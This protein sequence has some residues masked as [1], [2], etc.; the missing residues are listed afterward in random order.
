MR[1]FWLVIVVTIGILLAAPSPQRWGDGAAA[2][3]LATLPPVAERN[4]RFGIVFVNGAGYNASEQRYQ[5]AVASGV[6]WT[7]WPMYW[8]EIETSPGYLGDAAYSLQDEV[9]AG[10]VAHGLETNAILLGTPLWSATAGSLAV[11]VPRLEN[12]ASLFPSLS[13]PSGQPIPQSS[14]AASSP[15][16]LYLPVFLGDGTINPDN[17]WARF[18]YTTVSRYKGRVKVWEMWNEPDLKDSNGQPVFWS[19][20]YADYYQ[21]LKVGYQAA[22]AADPSATVLFAGLAYWTDTTFLPRLLD[23]MVADAT[24]PSHNYYFD[25]LPWHLYVSPYHL[26]NVPLWARSEMAGRGI[27]K[28]IWV[29]ETNIPVCSDTQV[30]PYLGCPTQWRGSLEEQAS[31][32]IQA[33]AMAAAAGVDKTFVFQLYDDDLGTYDW[34]GL[35]R[36]SASER[37]A[38]TSYQVAATYFAYPTRVVYQTIGSAIGVTFY[39]TSKGKVTALWNS[40]AVSTVAGI[41]AS[42]SPALLV[43]KYGNKTTIT[44][45]SGIYNISLPGTSYANGDVGGEPYLLVEPVRPAA[46]AVMEALPTYAS[47]K[48][49][50][51]R[52]SSGST[53]VRYDV[54]YWAEDRWVTWLE[55]TSATSAV[56]GPTSP[57]PVAE[58]T[59][60][61]FRVRARDAEGNADPYTPFPGDAQTT[62]PF[63]VTGGVTDYR[64]QPLSGASVLAVGSS[65]STT[66]SAAGTYRLGTYPQGTYLFAASRADFGQWPPKAI[67]MAGTIPYDFYLP[68]GDNLIANG[69]FEEGVTGWT[70]SG[71]VLAKTFRHSGDYGAYLSGTASLSQRVY[72]PRS[73][74]TLSLVYRTPATASPGQLTVRAIGVGGEKRLSQ[75]LNAEDAWRHAWIDLEALQGDVEVR[76]ELTGEGAV[77][78]LDEVSLGG[79]TR[80]P[81]Q[82]LPPPLLTPQPPSPSQT[83]RPP[84][85]H[86]QLVPLPPTPMP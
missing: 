52:W 85:P 7:R 28:P 41:Q 12:R 38:Y 10:D 46:S 37:P 64:G 81:V 39:G 84:P 25:G 56:F 67:A 61:N 6:R 74:A 60:Y 69:G 21:L 44:P 2:F 65:F 4:D 1:P 70:V 31:F 24:A 19:G 11:P 15:K 5:Q 77:L 63:F 82:P 45:T 51:V 29:N 26:Y 17:Y 18:V 86:P 47:G 80:L 79:E 36:N 3:S 16:N 23:L 58:G 53:S 22:K 35:I 76:F 30:S 62:V 78:W 48:S 68:P 14:V 33:Y 43:D 75:T 9:V 66:T 59:A 8:H 34:Y 55:N 83:P 72:V 40:S 32:I 42:A 13:Q 27:S 49:F 71:T 57:L 73:G 20:S 54:Q 50:P